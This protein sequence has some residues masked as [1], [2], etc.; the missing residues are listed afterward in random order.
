[1]DIRPEIRREGRAG[2]RATAADWLKTLVLLGLFA[3]AIVLLVWVQNN[4]RDNF[5]TELSA[6]ESY[7]ISYP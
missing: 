3:A 1:M 2:E 4:Y 7:P 5:L 6:P